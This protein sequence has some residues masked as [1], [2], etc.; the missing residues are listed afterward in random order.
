MAGKFKG[1][2]LWGNTVGLKAIRTTEEKYN[3]LSEAEKARTDVVYV[4]K[5]VIKSFL[6]MAN[7]IGYKNGKSVE[8]ELDALNNK[9][10]VIT[11]RTPSQAGWSPAEPYP[12]GFTKDNCCIIQI[13]FYPSN[14][15]VTHLGTGMYTDNSPTRLIPSFDNQG[16]HVYFSSTND[17]LYKDIPM[18]IVL[19]KL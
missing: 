11:S 14:G 1:K 4:Y 12:D 7:K 17:T 5:K 15:Q 3:E 19:M 13:V 16:I 6:M 8:E 9:F 18:K 10:Y 2:K